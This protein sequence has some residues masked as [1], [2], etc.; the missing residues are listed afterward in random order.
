ML[1]KKSHFIS[2]DRSDL[3]MIDNLSTA[4]HA[5]ARYMLTSLS[6]DELL[7]PRSGNLPI[8]FRGLPLGVMIA[9]SHLKHMYSVLFAFMWRPCLPLLAQ[10]NVIGIQL[11]QV[12]LQEAL[13]HFHRL[14]QE[15]YVLF[16]TNHGSNTPQNSSCM[17]AYFSSHL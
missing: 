15:C 3:N 14:H 6:V 12:Y 11:G 10:G 13:D 7:L 1:G 2:S 17:T 8:Y 16:W 4:V 5:F 9:P